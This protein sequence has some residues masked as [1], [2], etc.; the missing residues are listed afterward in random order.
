M[1]KYIYIYQ[2]RKGNFS[3]APTPK[4]IPGCNTLYKH[5]GMN[6]CNVLEIFNYTLGDFCWKKVNI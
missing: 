6:M 2:F 1:K 5:E 4:S 3:N